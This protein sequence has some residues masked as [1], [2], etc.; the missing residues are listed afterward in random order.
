MQRGRLLVSLGLVVFVTATTAAPASADKPTP[1]SASFPQELTVSTGSTCPPGAPPPPASF[2]F[3]GSDHSGQGTS[4]PPGPTKPAT[5]DFQG[6][7]DFT[8]TTTCA[9]GSTGFRDH[10]TVTIGTNTGQLFLTTD[11]VDC[12]SFGTDD[13]VWRAVGGTGMFKNAT[14]TGTVHTQATGGSGSPSD[15]IRSASTYSGQLVLQ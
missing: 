7:V 3:V 11:G 14:G 1:Y 15:P 13:G 2:C 9:D 10:N 4:T 12:P 6:F 8:Q 5:E